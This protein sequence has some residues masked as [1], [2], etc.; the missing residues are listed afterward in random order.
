[1]TL[2]P[3]GGHA[4]IKKDVV[5]FSNDPEQPKF[6]LTMKGRLLY[7]IEAVPP[8]VQIMNL[9]AG[10][11]GVVNVSL[12]RSEDSAATVTS[13]RIEDTE[14]FSI[15][16][17]DTAPN[18]LA[19][20]EVRF[21]GG[22][23]GNASTKL[24]VESTG[25]HNPQL[26]IPVRATTVHNL[27]YPKRVSFTKSASGS[28]EQDIRITTRRGDPPKIGKVEDPD[29]LLD[30]EV[31]AADGPTVTIHLRVRDT[32]KEGDKANHVLSVQ[33]ND[34]DEPKLAI[35]YSLRTS[36]AKNRARAQ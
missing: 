3:K 24:I 16:E 22:K 17:I 29:G 12:E 20:Y 1:V 36:A 5:V 6:T 11:A 34:P 7:D 9:A 18:A 31:L 4:V 14:R 2:K 27:V 19:T 23:V 30:I 15:R 33:T 28:L 25:Q 8:S 35:S 10:E 21:A 13:V 26:T 32:A